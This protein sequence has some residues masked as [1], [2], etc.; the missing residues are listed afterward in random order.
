MCDGRIHVEHSWGC[1]GCVDK[2]LC[3]CVVWIDNFQKSHDSEQNPDNSMSCFCPQKNCSL[4]LD[5]N[6]RR[7]RGRRCSKEHR[8]EASCVRGRYTTYIFT[9]RCSITHQRKSRTMTMTQPVQL[10][11]LVVL[12]VTVAMQL[13]HCKSCGKRPSGMTCETT[14]CGAEKKSVKMCCV[15]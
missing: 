7:H 13:G 9:Q 1:V 2:V 8:R 12:V 6:A 3:R 4:G 14:I 15:I 11:C 10:S 5:R